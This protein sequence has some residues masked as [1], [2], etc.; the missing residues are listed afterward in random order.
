[1]SELLIAP[2]SCSPASYVGTSGTSGARISERM[3][4]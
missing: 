1:M 4:I 2:D 3:K